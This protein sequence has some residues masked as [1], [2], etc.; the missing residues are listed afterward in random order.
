MGGIG[1]FRWKNMR[2]FGLKKNKERCCERK[3][4]HHHVLFITTRFGSY[5]K[6]W[7]FTDPCFNPPQSCNETKRF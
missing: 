5:K 1:I 3:G 7:D 2:S 4:I 6:K